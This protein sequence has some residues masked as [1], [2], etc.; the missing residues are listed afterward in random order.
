MI[1]LK[2]IPPGPQAG[3]QFLLY[4]P[5]GSPVPAWCVERAAKPPGATRRVTGHRGAGPRVPP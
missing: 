5:E 3:A 2:K 4:G 1:Y